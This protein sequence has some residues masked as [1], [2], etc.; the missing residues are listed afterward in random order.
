MKATSANSDWLNLGA[1]TGAVAVL[2]VGE[3]L[4]TVRDCACRRMGQRLSKT[5]WR[6][7]FL[8]IHF[9][10]ATYG[11]KNHAADEAYRTRSCRIFRFRK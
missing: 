2:A 7:I 5:N 8:Y 9:H 4:R 1:I 11:L 10:I 6:K 3:V